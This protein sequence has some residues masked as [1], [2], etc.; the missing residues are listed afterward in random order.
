MLGNYIIY[1]TNYFKY[2]NSF[3]MDGN[4]NSLWWWWNKDIS[5]ENVGI[6]FDSWWTQIE[7]TLGEFNKIAISER[8][9]A[10]SL[11]GKKFPKFPGPNDTGLNYDSLMVAIREVH[12]KMSEA[13]H[14]SNQR[15]ERLA[16]EL[17]GTE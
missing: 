4:K 10:R 16:R 9:V 1:Y 6:F 17:N 13:V 2:K 12:S 8:A 7:F 15:Y 5:R 14:S 11:L 3:N